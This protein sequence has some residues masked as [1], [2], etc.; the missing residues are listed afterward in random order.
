M[1]P[2][3]FSLDSYHLVELGTIKK[4]EKKAIWTAQAEQKFFKFQIYK[5]K[6][7]L[8]HIVFQKQAKN[9]IRK[10]FRATSTVVKIVGNA[11]LGGIFEVVLTVAHI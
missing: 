5:G 4:T 10:R 8:F 9:G 7:C 2:P 3:N 1:C 11:I 6:K